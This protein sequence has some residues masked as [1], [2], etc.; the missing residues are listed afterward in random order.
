VRRHRSIVNRVVLGLVGLALTGCGTGSVPSSASNASVPGPGSPDPSSV[1]WSSPSRT[2]ALPDGLDRVGWAWLDEHVDTNDNFVGAT[3]V[4]GLLGST[5]SLRVESSGQVAVGL[6]VLAVVRGEVGQFTI[7]IYR[8][9]TGA[10]LGQAEVVALVG[11]IQLDGERGLMYY[12]ATQTGVKSEIHRVRFDGSD[13]TVLVEL[14]PNHA[15]AEMPNGVDMSGYT[16]AADGTFVA[17][18]CDATGCNVRIAAPDDPAT[19]DIDV[20]GDTPS[21]CVVVGAT[22]R[23]LVAYDADACFADTDEAPLTVRVVDVAD[24]TTR[25]VNA[26]PNFEATGLVEAAAGPQIVVRQ[27]LANGGHSLSLVDVATGTRQVLIPTLP[28][29]VDTNGDT[30]SYAPWRD[31]LPAGWILLVPDR[32]DLPAEGAPPAPLVNVDGRTIEIPSWPAN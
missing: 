17:E 18:V 25:L 9:S 1:M 4:A 16:L 14:G 11:N 15:R 6:D 22:P 12:E 23:W 7:E 29:T 28:S 30:V 27:R 26:G 2:V 13:D 20:V 21:L 19:T 24:G 8:I 31:R 10:R 3:V 32:D 5:A